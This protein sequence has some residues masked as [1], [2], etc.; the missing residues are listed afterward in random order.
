T[1]TVPTAPTT[2]AA[3][4]SGASAG[5]STGPTA[6]PSSSGVVVE[7][8]VDGAG[9]YQLG[10]KLADLQTD[11]G[12]SNVT[13]GGQPCPQDPAAPRTLP[14]GHRRPRHRR[15]EGRVPLLP[16]RR[17]ALPGGQQVDVDPDAVG[18]LAR[19]PVAAA[20][21]DLRTGA[22]AGPGR[23]GTQGLPGHHAVRPWH[24]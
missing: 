22:D 20:Q 19:H 16:Q 6:T 21:K 10:N 24:P 18:R 8:S 13:A 23:R 14:A 17:R 7:F 11:P 2:G 4:P 1:V 3:P 5:P 15:V 12:L 9:P